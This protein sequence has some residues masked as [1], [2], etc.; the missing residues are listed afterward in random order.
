[1]REFAKENNTINGRPAS[2]IKLQARTL[3]L[4][5]RPSVGKKIAIAIFAFTGFT[6]IIAAIIFAFLWWVTSGGG[7]GA[8]AAVTIII[9]GLGFIADIMIERD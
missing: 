3:V 5:P 7:F 9:G 1:M 8:I 6:G 2:E 4:P